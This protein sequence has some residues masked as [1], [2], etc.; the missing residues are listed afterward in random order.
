MQMRVAE[1]KKLP[2]QAGVA[3]LEWFRENDRLPSRNGRNIRLRRR[4]E[5]EFYPLQN[6]E[7]FL[8]RL[9]PDNPKDYVWFGGTDQAPFLTTLK[10]AAFLALA[11]GGEKAFYEALKP[12]IIARAE[13]FWGAD[14]TRR[15]G[16][17]F[18]YPIPKGWDVILAEWV[19]NIT[20]RTYKLQ[21]NW[22]RR[23]TEVLNTRHTL[24][25]MLFQGD[26]WLDGIGRLYAD[27]HPLADFYPRMVLGEGHLNAPDHTQLDL[28]GPHIIA[29]AHLLQE[30]AANRE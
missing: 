17:I 16:D 10:P 20:T 21:Q 23:G 19:N 5:A 18:T 12:P 13:L 24:S 3:T 26:F 28:K 22:N 30:P 6:G 1:I 25:G 11:S 8:Y 29:Q 2:K 27:N 4:A 7:Q 15:Q 9:Y 14:K